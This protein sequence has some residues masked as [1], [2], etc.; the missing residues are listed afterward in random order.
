[1]YLF[2]IRRITQYY[3]HTALLHDVVVYC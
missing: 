1:M 3:I 2:V